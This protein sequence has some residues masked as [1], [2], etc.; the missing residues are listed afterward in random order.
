MSIEQEGTA[1]KRSLMDEDTWDDPSILITAEVISGEPI[2]DDDVDK[3]DP[4][5]DEADA[6]SEGKRPC[7]APEG[8]KQEILTFI[9]HLRSYG[10]GRG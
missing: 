3:G 10:C 6:P 9:L 1:A 7:V 8:P 5:G 2:E 4:R